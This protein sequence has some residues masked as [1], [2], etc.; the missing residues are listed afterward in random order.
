MF[1]LHGYFAFISCLFVSLVV[2]VLFYPCV[3][4]ACVRQFLRYFLLGYMEKLGNN[5]NE[6]RRLT[7]RDLNFISIVFVV[8]NI[9]FLCTY[10]YYE[11]KH[12]IKIEQNWSEQ[13]IKQILRRLKYSAEKNAIDDVNIHTRTNLSH[14]LEEFTTQTF[15][16]CSIKNSHKYQKEVMSVLSKSAVFHVTSTGHC[17]CDLRP[18]MKWKK[19]K[20][21][22]PSPQTALHSVHVSLMSLTLAQFIFSFRTADRPDI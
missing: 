3:P 4:Y 14:L 13:Q 7:T 5:L 15:L 19:A 1:F 16:K 8:V 9:N 12:S 20:Y 11:W 17:V 10:I 21:I 6:T 18:R 22:Y 2:S